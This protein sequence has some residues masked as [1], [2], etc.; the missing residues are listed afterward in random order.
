M[1]N[2]EA[3]SGEYADDVASTMDIADEEDAE[4]AADKI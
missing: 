1:N 3:L 2:S 4:T